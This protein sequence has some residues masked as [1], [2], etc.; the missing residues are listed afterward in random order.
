MPGGEI[1]KVRVLG[2]GT[3]GTRISLICAVRGGCGVT[4]YDNSEEVPQRIPF[5]HKQSGQG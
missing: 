4:V 5:R 2:A 1:R 3:M